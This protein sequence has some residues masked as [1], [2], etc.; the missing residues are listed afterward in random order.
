MLTR[1]PDSEVM[2]ARITVL[3]SLCVVQIGE[4]SCVVAVF[5]LPSQRC[6]QAAFLTS[7]MLSFFT[8]RMLEPGLANVLFSGQRSE[9]DWCTPAWPRAIALCSVPGVG[10]RGQL[11]RLGFF[12]PPCELIHLN[13]EELWVNT[14]QHYSLRCLLQQCSEDQVMQSI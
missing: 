5:V 11:G 2:C 13:L 4:Q 6:F 9:L 8:R 1:T 14:A 3:L 7:C 12:R 10:G